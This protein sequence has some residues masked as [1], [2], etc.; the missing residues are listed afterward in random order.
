VKEGG[1]MGTCW[2]KELVGIHRG[3]GLGMGIWS[4]ENFRA[5]GG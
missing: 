3:V 2:W 4:N 1:K 5:D